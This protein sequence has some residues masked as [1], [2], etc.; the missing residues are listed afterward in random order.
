MSF[1][2]NLLNLLRDENPNVVKAS[3]L[4]LG[5]L[6]EKI[7]EKSIV[8]FLK[9]KIWQI[10]EATVKTI[11]ML[12]LKD[13]LPFLFQRLG[14]KKETGRKNILDLLSM[15]VAGAIKEEEDTKIETHPRVKKAIA[16]A[17]ANIDED[18]L[19]KP[20]INSLKSENMNMVLAAINGLGNIGNELAVTPLMEFL[21]A[22]DIKILRAVIV[23]LGKIKSE[24]PVEKLMELSTHKSEIIRKEVVIALNHIKS[25]KGIDVFIRLIDDES[26]EVRKTAVI[27]LGNTKDEKNLS[28]LLKKAKDNA[29]QVRKAV[30]SSLINY[31]TKEVLDTLIELICDDN[32][33]VKAEA[34]IVFNKIYPLVI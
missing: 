32:Q 1:R 30:A 20:L 27:A 18:Y 29:W 7:N 5:Y 21:N 31:R 23:A 12:K 26:I 9:H 3:L 17:I 15:K 6:G 10:R 2:D 28:T 13:A 19:L 22:S 34:S 25:P 24:K 8:P 33:E 16:H 4:S 11:E 14:I